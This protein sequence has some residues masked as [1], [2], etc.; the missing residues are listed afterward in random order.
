MSRSDAFI[1]VTCDKCGYCETYDLCAI[2]CN[3]WDERHISS[4]LKKDG[5]N[6]EGQDLCE[7]CVEDVE[8]EP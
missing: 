7:S 1:T 8:D 3:G 2:A 5:W 6:I 4:R